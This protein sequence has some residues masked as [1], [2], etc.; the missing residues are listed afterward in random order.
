MARRRP[1]R[2]AFL[3]AVAAG[4]V[5][6][7]VLSDAS[8]RNGDRIV[9]FAEQRQEKPALESAGDW[10]GD[11]VCRA[12]FSVRPAWS[13]PVAARAAS[14]RC[15]RWVAAAGVNGA[16]PVAELRTTRTIGL[17]GPMTSGFPPGAERA[18]FPH[19]HLSA[20]TGS[21]I[22]AMP[23]R[24]MPRRAVRTLNVVQCWRLSS[25][26]G[27]FADVVGRIDAAASL[28]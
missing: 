3:L 5:E 24:A 20:P 19:C 4:A 11:R 2:H 13:L 8:P 17:R 22:P 27:G 14:R 9:A 12:R 18:G 21:S 1:L 7:G 28:T 25:A 15:R 6:A 10:A 16:L 23:A 26:V